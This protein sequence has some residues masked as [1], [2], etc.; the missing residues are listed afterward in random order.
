MA[1]T[2]VSLLGDIVPAH[3]LDRVLKITQLSSN[4]ANSVIAFIGEI[5]S[6]T[7]Q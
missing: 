2:Y 3:G 7:S 4:N 1:A 5:T 6:S